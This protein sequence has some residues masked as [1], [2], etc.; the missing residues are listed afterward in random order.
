MADAEALRGGTHRGT[1][2]GYSQGYSQ[3]CSRVPVHYE[4]AGWLTPKRCARTSRGVLVGYS[5]AFVRV[6]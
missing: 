6:L 1:Q 2:Q 4:E 3:G 5:R